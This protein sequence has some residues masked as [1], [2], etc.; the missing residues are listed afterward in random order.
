MLVAALGALLLLQYGAKK[1]NPL[2]I[3]IGSISPLMNFK[4]VRVEGLLESGARQLRSGSV[5]YVIDDGTGVLSVFSDAS[6]G[7][8]LPMAGSRVAAIGN[9][10]VGIGNNVRMQAGSIELLE[11]PPAENYISEFRLSDITAELVD[12][13][14]TAF[15]TVF[16]VWKP[17]P[18]SKAPYKIILSDPSGTLDVVHWLKNSAGGGDR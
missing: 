15:G 2:L 11:E 14:I 18:G 13:R 5:L 12:V 3:S 6:T 17:R 10:S 9:L 8:K 16:K 7:A 1:R 4:A